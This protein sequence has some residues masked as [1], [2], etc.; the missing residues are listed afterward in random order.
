MQ[1]LHPWE[2]ATRAWLESFPD[3]RPPTEP[4]VS[5][6]VDAL[7]PELPSLLALLGDQYFRR[8]VPIEEQNV[9][10]NILDTA[11]EGYEMD[12]SRFCRELSDNVLLDKVVKHFNG[13][14]RESVVEIL[15]S[16]E[17]EFKIYRKNRK[18]IM[19]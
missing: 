13:S 3:G 15:D 11:Q 9:I 12:W 2:I 1:P 6:Y 8:A 5:A 10:A 7:R 17:S 19:M 16:L 18:Y 14:T 4:E